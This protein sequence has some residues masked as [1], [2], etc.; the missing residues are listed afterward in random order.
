MSGARI[1]LLRGTALNKSAVVK[2]M[3]IASASA[4]GALSVSNNNTLLSIPSAFAFGFSKARELLNDNVKREDDPAI[5]AQLKKE[6]EDFNKE[7]QLYHKLS[8]GGLPALT[9]GVSADD[10]A[11]FEE[12]ERFLKSYAPLSTKVVRSEDNSLSI[13]NSLLPE[14]SENKTYNPVVPVA[15][16][17]PAAANLISV[18]SDQKNAIVN[19]HQTMG[20]MALHLQAISEK[21]LSLPSVYVNP[22]IKL[23]PNVVSTLQIDK[24]VPL[25]FPAEILKYNELISQKVTDVAEVISEKAEYEKTATAIRDLNGEVVTTA[26]PRD[27]A[28]SYQATRAKTATDEND[29]ELSDND[30]N[31]LFPDFPD[32]RD[33]FK[34][35]TSEEVYNSLKGKEGI[36]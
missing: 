17:A 35:Q 20:A 36:L 14:R 31:L 21:K 3:A 11:K 12:L 18:I 24:P 9:D 25:E 16:S 8:T 28:L 32:I 5:Q 33:I 4:L 27:I 1:A 15:P 26:T 34:F 29:F 23:K 6:I 10:K 2:K 7:Q 30:V 19:L 13:G 22:S